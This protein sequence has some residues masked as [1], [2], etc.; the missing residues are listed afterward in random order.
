MISEAVMNSAKHGQATK[1][2]VS[3]ATREDR[4]WIR[5]SDDGIGFPFRGRHDLASMVAKQQGPSVLAERVAALNGELTVESTEEGATL[6]I[7]LP[8][9]WRAE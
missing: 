7:E 8:L 2:M 3:L 4:L 9:G 5:V 1:V 6:E